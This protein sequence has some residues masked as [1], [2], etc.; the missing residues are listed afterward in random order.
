VHVLGIQ[1][2]LYCGR[3]WST[4]NMALAQDTFGPCGQTYGFGCLRYFG[5]AQKTVLIERPSLHLQADTDPLAQRDVVLATYCIANSAER[6]RCAPWALHLKR[7]TT[8][9]R[10]SGRNMLRLQGI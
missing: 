1:P 3:Y 5:R 7:T 10:F 2:S 9:K 6:G 8:A 4:S